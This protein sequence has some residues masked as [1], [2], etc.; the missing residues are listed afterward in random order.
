MKVIEGGG[1]KRAR[2]NC[3]S[4]YGIQTDKGPDGKPRDFKVPKKADHIAAELLQKTG[5]FPKRVGSRLF[6]I[7]DKNEIIWIDSSPK[8]FAE[9]N[10]R[11]EI[12]MAWGHVEGA[13][14]KNEFFEFLKGKV[15]RFE[16]VSTMSHHPERSEIFYSLPQKI[17]TVATNSCYHFR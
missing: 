12:K 5:G 8:L 16:M 15:E 11:F 4:N 17:E 6:V 14:N 10:G 9:M 7:G 3:L 1:A 2:Q 13:I